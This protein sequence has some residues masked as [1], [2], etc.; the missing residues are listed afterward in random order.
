MDVPHGFAYHENTWD[1]ATRLAEMEQ[2]FSALTARTCK[3][4]TFVAS[5]SNFAR[6]ARSG[7]QGDG[8]TAAGS[9]DPWSF[10][11]NRNTRRRLDTFSSPED[12]HARSAVLLRFPC[13]QYTLEF[14]TRS[15]ASW[16]SPTYQPTTADSCSRRELNV[17]ILRRVTKIMVSPKK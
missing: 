14:L 6:L 2:N 16:K 5:A 15:I 1:I 17:K 12:K 7:E 8:S 10:D 9:H 11:D 3:F 4:E 13:E